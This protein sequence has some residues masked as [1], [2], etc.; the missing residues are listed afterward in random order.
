MIWHIMKC[1]SLNVI[2]HSDRVP[3]IFSGR[4]HS[5]SFSSSS[6]YLRKMLHVE[7]AMIIEYSLNSIYHHRA[8]SIR[9]TIKSQKLWHFWHLL[10]CWRLKYFF[11]IELT[12]CI[13]LCLLRCWLMKWR[14]TFAIFD[15]LCYVETSFIELVSCSN[16]LKSIVKGL[17][18]LFSM[19][20][21]LLNS[22]D[23]TTFRWSVCIER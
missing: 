9:R 8:F 10:R 3:R 21:V 15:A 13:L 19:F 4:F 6:S 14:K 16:H 2:S 22:L 17:K 20:A 18:L 7:T 12:L 11:F 1:C 23:C 5:I